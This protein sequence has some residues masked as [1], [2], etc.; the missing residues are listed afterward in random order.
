MTKGKKLKEK[1]F[2]YNQLQ[3]ISNKTEKLEK[4]TR[5]KVI[6]KART[7]R[8]LKRDGIDASNIISSRRV[9]R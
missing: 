2:R 7:D 9:K 8:I 3:K 1:E 5:S 4:K 6:Q